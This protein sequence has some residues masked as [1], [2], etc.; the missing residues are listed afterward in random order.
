MRDPRYA[1]YFPAYFTEERARSCH[2]SQ[3]IGSSTIGLAYL[4]K[5]PLHWSSLQDLARLRIGVVAGFSN[6][7][8]FDAWMRDGRLRPD[9][10]PNDMLNLR[11]LLADRVD[12]VVIDKL[13]LLYLLASEPSLMRDRQLIAFHQRPLAE[14]ALH[15]CFKRSPAGLA[16]QRSFDAALQRLSLRQLETEYF[17]RLENNTPNR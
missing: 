11:K 7:P 5:T 16:I 1:G 14:L 10:A 15:V 9:P 2:F 6:G 8:E 12:A 13:V 4:K 17:L 3:P